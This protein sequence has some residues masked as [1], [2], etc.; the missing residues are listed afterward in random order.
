M[1]TQQIQGFKPILAQRRRRWPNVKLALVQRL[2]F[3]VLNGGCNVGLMI[4]KCLRRRS[5]VDPTWVERIYVMCK[6]PLLIDPANLLSS[7]DTLWP[8]SNMVPVKDIE[9]RDQ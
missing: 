3:A 7:E 5:N 2:E 1:Y 6:T 9:G 4:G 8:R